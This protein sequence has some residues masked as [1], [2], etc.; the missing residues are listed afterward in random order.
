MIGLQEGLQ[1]PHHFGNRQQ[2]AETRALVKDEKMTLGD[3]ERVKISRIL[4]VLSHPGLDTLIDQ[5]QITLGI[6]KPHAN[7]G[8][9]LPEDDEEAAQAVLREIGDENIVFTFS[10]KL[11]PEEA[12]DFYRDIK[13]KYSRVKDESGRSVW[14]RINEF[15]QSG[16]LTFL[17]IHR[18]E[19][20]A[21]SWWRNKMGATKANEADPASIRGKYAIQEKLPNNIT[22]GSDSVESVRKEVGVLREVVSRIYEDIERTNRFF[23]SGKLLQRLQFLGVDEELI[24]IQRIFDSGRMAESWIYG[25]EVKYKDKDG[26]LKTK[27]LKEKNLI[28]AGGDLSYK[29]EVQERRFREVGQ[30]GIPIA[31]F[32]GRDGASLYFDFIRED[33]AAEIYNRINREDLSVETKGPLDQL[34]NIAQK[35]DSRGFRPLKL[36]DEFIYDA[37]SGSFYLV[38]VGIDL[39]PNGTDKTTK[40]L[41]ALTSRFPSKAEY[42]RGQYAEASELVSK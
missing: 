36:L 30:M 35:L 15:V 16:P 33:G 29:T 1:T 10:T 40:S 28:S 3:L 23:P 39:G 13:E 25:F 32:Y 24:S 5:G 22:H 18:E 26:N 41:D 19:G 20:D 31:P 27:Y 2:G 8:R 7:E 34:I 6:I 14:D 17:I 37:L 21:V 12:E 42:I 38:D 9:G 11:N 4:D